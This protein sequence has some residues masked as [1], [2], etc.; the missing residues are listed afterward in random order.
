MSSVVDLILGLPAWLVLTLVAVLPALEASMFLGLV[1]P[2]EV[3][4]L[5]GGVVAHAGGLP[6]WAVIAAAVAGATAGDQVGYLLGRRYGRTLLDR[7]PTWMRRS[8]DVERALAQMERRGAVAVALGR[9][10]AALRALMPGLA[11][12]SQMPRLPFTVANVAGGTLWATTVAVL[13]FL[14]A[15]SLHSLESRL[16]LGSEALTAAVLLILV[17][18]AVRRH[19]AQRPRQTNA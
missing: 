7:L 14:G 2:G 19:R 11:G 16:G 6:L 5:V 9:W 12:M 15:A 18:F 17:V 4:I 8:G 13:G 3:A 1:F 10:A